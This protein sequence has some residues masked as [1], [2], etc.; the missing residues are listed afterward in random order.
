MS[1]E[2]EAHCIKSLFCLSI[3]NLNT[4]TVKTGALLY[5]AKFKTNFSNGEKHFPVRFYRH[6]H[7]YLFSKFGNDNGKV[8]E[9]LVCGERWSDDSRAFDWPTNFHK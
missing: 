7:S 6:F 5:R 3:P 8:V 9:T 2:Y 4:R 1:G